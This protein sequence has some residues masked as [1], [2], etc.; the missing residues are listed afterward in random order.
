MMLIFLFLE[1]GHM[2]VRSFM[3]CEC[4]SAPIDAQ[5]S[6]SCESNI[7]IILPT[8]LGVVGGCLWRTN[9]PQAI[10]HTQKHIELRAHS[11]TQK[12]GKYDADFPCWKLGT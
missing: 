3:V 10:M 12:C 5:S 9:T 2:M 1:A 6:A 4:A 8:F 7:R 11:H